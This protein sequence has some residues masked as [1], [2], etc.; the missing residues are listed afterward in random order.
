VA[1]HR[2]SNNSGAQTHWFG[3]YQELGKTEARR[4]FLHLIDD[5][6]TESTTV[7]ITDRGQPVAVIMGYKHYKILIEALDQDHEVQAHPL[8]GLIIKVGDLEADSKQIKKLF[9]QSVQNTRE[10]L[11]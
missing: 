1:E 9:R 4:L 7:A 8:D 6:R 2:A 11:Q 5:L 10:S 3:Q